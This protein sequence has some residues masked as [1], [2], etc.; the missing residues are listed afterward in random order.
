[1]RF[2]GLALAASALVLGACAGGDTATTDTAAAAADTMATSAA[3]AP[4]TGDTGAMAAAPAGGTGN[5]VRVRMILE[6]TAY[7]YVPENVTVKAGDV[8]EFVNESGGPHNVCFKPDQVQ[9][10]VLSQ[11]DAGMPAQPGAKLGKAC[12]PL[13]TEPNAVYRLAT[14][15]VTAGSYPFVCTPHEALGMKGTLT[16]Q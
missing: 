12:G 9:D 6:G 15:G 4:A 13:L 7:K 1:M 5:T 8:I 14:A 3:P 16:V 2:Y 11:L 10:P